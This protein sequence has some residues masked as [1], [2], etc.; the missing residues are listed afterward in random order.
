MLVEELLF[1][2]YIKPPYTNADKWNV[3]NY[4]MLI[5]IRVISIVNQREKVNYMNNKNASKFT[6]VEEGLEVDWA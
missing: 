1:N 6:K 4:N 3:K 2:H 5:N